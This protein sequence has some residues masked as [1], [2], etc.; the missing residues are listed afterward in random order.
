MK[1][2]FYIGY[3]DQAPPALAR[4][5][6]RVVVTLVLAVTMI[7]GL[8]AARQTPAD[9]GTFEFGVT[10]S[11]EGV[12]YETPLPWLRTLS[13]AGAGTNYLLVG[14]GKQGLPAFARG[15][16]GDQVRFQGSL[17]YR[18][19]AVMIELNQPNSFEVIGRAVA[20]D[21]RPRSEPVG[22]AVLTGELVDTKCWYGVM[23]PATGKV[24][25]ACAVRCLSGGVP[26]GLLVRDAEGNATVVLL[27]GADGTPLRYDVEWAARI[28]TAS[29]KLELQEQTPVLRVQKLVLGEAAH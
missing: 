21:L 28:V 1:D 7:L 15:H 2:D 13:A 24:H 20:K 6:R 14:S 8:L 29:G 26:P 22:E 4:H 10:R 17:I 11:F 23:R 19:K 12:L 16:D 18:G 25:R 27:A 3:L 9:Q 5:T